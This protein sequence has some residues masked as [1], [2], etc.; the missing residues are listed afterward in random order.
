MSRLTA[1]VQ[2][3]MARQMYVFLAI[4]IGGGL[5]S[6][7]R[8]LLASAI[9]RYT[10]D[11]FPWGTLGVNILGGLMMGVLV[12]FMALRWSVTPEIRLFLT[13]GLLGG[14]TTFSAFS[15]ET[16]SMIE[17]GDWTPAIL[18]VL[19]SVIVSILAL[20]AGL[21]LVRGLAA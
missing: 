9:G 7:G 14:F 15:L 18:Y 5:G 13:T 12:E 10:H 19:A 20:F 21:A 11:G 3:T 6:L 2:P 8:Y 16:A 1:K 17:R 4:F